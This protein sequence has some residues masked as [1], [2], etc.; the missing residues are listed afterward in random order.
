MIFFSDCQQISKIDLLKKLPE[1]SL[2]A[3][4]TRSRRL[5]TLRGFLRWAFSEKYLSEDLSVLLG[6]SRS[7]L[8]LPTFITPDEAL[9]LWSALN[10]KREREDRV[11]QLI[12]LLM[13][14]SGLRVSEVA[15]A[16]VDHLN[17]DKTCL[18]LVG[19]GQKPRVV[20]LLLQTREVLFELSP[21]N[22]LVEKTDGNPFCTRPLHRRIRRMGLEAG[23]ERLLHPHMLRHSFATHLLEGGGNLRTIQSLLGHSSLSTTQKYTHITLDALARTLESRHPLR[24]K[25]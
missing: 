3:A 9:T 14:G 5:S 7:T 15:S 11:D 23:L 2:H 6:R 20:P 8:K 16:R 1:L 13:Y 25:K 12:F 22:H 21:Q 10:S 18:S 4:S 19:K 17:G 24:Q